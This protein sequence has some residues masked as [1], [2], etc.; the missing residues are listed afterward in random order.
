MGAS[1]TRRAVIDSAPPSSPM[2]QEVQMNIGS[3]LVRELKPYPNNARTHSKKQVR[4]I[5]NSI[6]RFGFNNPVL[7]DENN[8]VIAG[9]GRVEAAKLLGLHAVPT[10]QLSHMIEADKRAYVLADNKLG[11]QAGW[12]R[13]ML[14]IELHGLTDLGIDM[15]L[16][17]FEMPEVDVILDEAKEAKDCPPTPEDASPSYSSEAAVTCAGDL[18]VLGE[19]RLFCGDA[20]E[21]SSYEVLLG[22]TRAEFVFTD[23][24]YNVPIEGNVGGLGRIRHK[25]FAMGCGEMNEE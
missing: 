5:A 14:A 16:T 17:G 24:P 10:I 9:H 18:W 2:T 23:P 19:H 11:L 22:G 12:D 25:N 21:Q 13:E 8:Q 7:I 1:L 20:R 15:E 3:T 4:R 6:D